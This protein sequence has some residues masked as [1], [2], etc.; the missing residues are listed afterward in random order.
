MSWSAMSWSQGAALILVIA[1]GGWIGWE[2]Y[3]IHRDR[4]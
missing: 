4:R 3:I 2:I 1:I